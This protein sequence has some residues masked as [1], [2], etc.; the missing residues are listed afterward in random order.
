MIVQII[1][2][3]QG[4]ALIQ[5]ESDGYLHRGIVP[6]EIIID[7]VVDD[8][9]LSLAIPYGVDWEFVMGSSRTITWK[10]IANCLRKAG[11]WTLVDLRMNPQAVLGAIQTAYR[12]DAQ[13]MRAYGEQFEKE[14]KDNG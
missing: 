14:L 3:E 13:M 8:T 11:I 12:L 9:L 2:V 4:R 10:D 7:N 1:N 5:Y 6:E